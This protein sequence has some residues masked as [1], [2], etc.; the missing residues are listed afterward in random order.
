M[1]K[2]LARPAK[3]VSK[4]PMP[5]MGGPE[6]PGKRRAK[7][8]APNL[9]VSGLPSKRGA[10]F[11][12]LSKEDKALHLNLEKMLQLSVASGPATPFDLED[13]LTRLRARRAR[14]AA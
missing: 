11:D 8:H 13:T 5:D 10:A 2:K 4:K 3:K 14:R 9:D 12:S 1:K 6:L 7:P